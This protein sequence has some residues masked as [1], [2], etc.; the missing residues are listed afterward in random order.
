[1]HPQYHKE[2]TEH[3]PIERMPFVEKY[4]VPLSQHIGAPSLPIVQKGERVK[5]GA[6]IAKPGGVVSVALHSPVSGTVLAIEPA[7]H[8]NGQQ[9]PAIKIQT[10]LFATQRLAQPP[11]AWE[12][13]AVE[14]FL[15]LIQSAGIVGLGGA[16]FPSHVKFSIPPEKHCQF[17]I[18][19]GCECEPFLTADHRIMVEQ[20]PQLIQGARI[21]AH[22]LAVEKTFIGIEANK[23]DA[24][25]ILSEMAPRQEFP[26]EVLPLQVK[27]PQ[28]AEK[29]LISAILNKEVPS[30][31]LPLDVGSVV[32][33]VGTLVAIADYFT[34]SQPLI[35]RVVTVTG[36]GIRRPANLL[37]PI[38]TPLREVIE[39][40]G[41]LDAATTRILLGGPMMGVVQKNLDVPVLK[42]TSGIIALTEEAVPETTTYQCIRCGRCLQACPLFL[43]PSLLGLMARKGLYEEMKQAHLMDCMECACCSYVCPS[44][45]PLVQ[46]FRVAK[47][48]LR[49]REGVHG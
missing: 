10:D 40:C 38:G 11:I 22:F 21:L 39:T 25:Q 46:S 19:N 36:P 26:L 8:P 30:G 18:V 6:M 24:I 12:H 48:I 33:N 2:L 16:A 45:I 32:T 29:M 47:A 49:E 23:P 20:A 4:T 1:M 44:G 15:N 27:Y 43:N 5:R 34:K 7:E 31:K 3:L 41:G 37:V 14:E 13:L 42:G 9:L 28:G 17:S 35:E